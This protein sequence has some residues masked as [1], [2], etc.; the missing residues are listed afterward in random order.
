MATLKNTV[1]DSTESIVLPT[2][3]TSQRPS[4]P[5]AGMMRYNTDLDIVEIY[6]GNSWV[7]FTTAQGETQLS[8][9][10]L[11]MH[12]DAGISDSYS[13][14]GSTWSDLSGNN[15]NMV[16]F[17]TSYN[18]DY[19]K[20]FVFNG[21][22]SYTVSDNFFY[23]GQSVSEITV[24]IWYKSADN[25]T[26]ILASWDRNEY[27]RIEHGNEGGTAPGR[28]GIAIEQSTGS[29]I[30]NFSTVTQI[31]ENE[32]A[33]F[34]WTFDNGTTRVYT[35]GSLENT[36]TGLTSTIFQGG[37]RYGGLGVGSE[38]E[39]FNS[40]K[41]PDDPDD[42]YDG[43]IAIFQIYE[44]SLSSNEVQENYNANRRRFGK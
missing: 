37:T 44:R 24:N 27:F 18:S 22:N 12:V 15:N 7:E 34:T 32:W 43:E 9:S 31:P 8:S 33:M 1:I 21:S 26:G 10:G 29:Q 17:N 41:G 4:S 40:T 20:S 5:S 14:S 39:S 36:L 2:G 38:Q 19:P 16:L 42:Y 13:G 30:D 35:N 28:V 6:N 11:V 23:T 25:T 3:S